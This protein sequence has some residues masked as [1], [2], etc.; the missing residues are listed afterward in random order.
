MSDR[1]FGLSSPAMG[2]GPTTE[3]VSSWESLATAGLEMSYDVPQT[4][5]TYLAANYPRVSQ[6][7]EGPKKLRLWGRHRYAKAQSEYL[8]ADAR[9]NRGNDTKHNNW[10]DTVA[11]ICIEAGGLALMAGDEDFADELLSSERVP[12]G[13]AGQSDMLG[14]A[15]LAS[16]HSDDAK[17]I[18]LRGSIPPKSYLH[19]HNLLDAYR[20]TDDPDYRA[21]AVLNFHD[22]PYMLAR[23]AAHELSQGRSAEDLFNV[24]EGHWGARIAVAAVLARSS[25]ETTAGRY[26][27]YLDKQVAAMKPPAKQ[28]KTR[29]EMA[30]EAVVDAVRD[31]GIIAPVSFMLSAIETG[32]DVLAGNGLPD[33][34]PQPTEE[35]TLWWNQTS[36]LLAEINP[37][38]VGRSGYDENL[39]RLSEAVADKANS[40]DVQIERADWADPKAA[41][42]A[43][44]HK[45]GK[46][47]SKLLAYR[48]LLRDNGPVGAMNY[49][50]HVPR[51][52]RRQATYYTL[53]SFA[54]NGAEMPIPN[55]PDMTDTYGPLLELDR[56]VREVASSSDE[57]VDEEAIE[58]A[59]TAAQVNVTNLRT[60]TAVELASLRAKILAIR[61]PED[62]AYELR[63]L[64][65]EDA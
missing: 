31:E 41:L 8:A 43:L 7:V 33:T 39:S 3:L 4:F 5:D 63:K 9:L 35:Y 40:F 45:Q 28:W 14:M 58:L 24:A 54:L 48:H 27:R 2:P 50:Q 49:V 10:Q 13:R 61:D 34:S 22:Q 29:G 15:M 62:R 44:R 26:E 46:A 51:A 25:D 11:Q 65:G 37:H 16:G 17:H 19:G 21:S 1:R 32:M 36:S 57:S 60:V 18:L 56:R 55:L 6:K 20:A 30:K 52:Y 38:L 53:V 23:L 59:G 47:I 64:L 12:E 42:R